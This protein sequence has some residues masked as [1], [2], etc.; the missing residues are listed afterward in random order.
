MKRDEVLAEVCAAPGIEPLEL[1]GILGQG[2]TDR[3]DSFLCPAL[4]QGFDA[5]VTTE[6]YY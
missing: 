5:F 3:S 2:Y 6:R 1:P 4:C